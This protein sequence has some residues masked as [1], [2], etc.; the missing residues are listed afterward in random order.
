MGLRTVV[1]GM[2]TE[3]WEIDLIY[4]EK[5]DVCVYFVDKKKRRGFD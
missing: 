3:D 5:E 1:R 4:L 2:V